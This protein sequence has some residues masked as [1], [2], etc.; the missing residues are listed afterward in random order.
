MYIILYIFFYG[1]K[2]IRYILFAYMYQNHLI[3]QVNKTIHQMS[4]YFIMK[5]NIVTNTFF[6]NDYRGIF[7]KV[8]AT[9]ESGE[10]NKIIVTSSINYRTFVST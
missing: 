7:L 1:I 9:R 4:T 6:K 10:T 8:F 5:K 2:I 3:L